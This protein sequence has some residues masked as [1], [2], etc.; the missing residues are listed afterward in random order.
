MSTHLVCYH[1]KMSTLTLDEILANFELSPD[2]QLIRKKNNS[3]LRSKTTGYIRPD[4]YIHVQYKNQKY[5]AH[6]L[7][8]QIIHLMDSLPDKIQIDHV[9][10]NRRNNHSDNLRLATNLQN[11]W[12]GKIH[13]NNT[14]GYKG[15]TFDKASKKWKAAIRHGNKL[16]NL[17]RFNS[18]EDAHLAY[19]NKAIEL[20]GAFARCE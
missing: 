1:T 14:S 20:F 17:G 18:P 9:D 6:R 5:Y 11:Q 2:Y 3:K 7:I 4:G 19:K 16:L 10:G 15:V 12:N 8:Y 13:S